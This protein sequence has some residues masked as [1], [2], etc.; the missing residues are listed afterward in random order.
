VL[1]LDHHFVSLF[2]H[3]FDR[4]LVAEPV[5]TLDGIVHVPRPV[6]LLGI[7]ERGSHTTLRRNRVRTR[8]EDL[9]QHSRL[10]AGF[11]QLDSRTQTGATGTDDHRIK[12]ENRNTH[13]YSLQRIAA[14]HAA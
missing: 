3:E 12:F 2:A 4:V 1:K 8:R 9:G 10:Q 14:A 11:G 13:A 6:I 7:A 5:G